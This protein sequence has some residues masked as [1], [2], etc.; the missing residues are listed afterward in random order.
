MSQ[1]CIKRFLEEDA[2]VKEAKVKRHAH[3]APSTRSIDMDPARLTVARTIHGPVLGE[4][5]DT[6]CYGCGGKLAWRVPHERSRNGIAFPVVGHFMHV[7]CEGSCT[8]E[9]V[10]HA[11]AKDMI[12]K[13]TPRVLFKCGS[14]STDYEVVVRANGSEPVAEHPWSH[15]GQQYRLDVAFVQDGMTT[16]AVEILHSHKVS[17]EK[18]RALTI[19]D[20]AWVELA[21]GDVL[22]AKRDEPVRALRCAVQRCT[23]CEE[24]KT[25]IEKN[26]AKLRAE[27]EARAEVLLATRLPALANHEQRMCWEQRADR[28]LWKTVREVVEK[29]L[30]ERGVTTTNDSID[31]V[32]E[33]S[34]VVATGGIVLCHGKHRGEVLNDVWESDQ[35][36]VRWLAGYTGN[37]E[38]KYPEKVTAE[39]NPLARGFVM[40]EV[41]AAREILKGHC[42]LCFQEVDQPWKSWCRRCFH[43]SEI[44]L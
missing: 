37:R 25:A 20:V 11:A 41:E 28:E 34:E 17:S 38:G 7:S 43:V 40:L 12:M 30:H 35:P 23:Q 18:A 5:D 13:C 42:Y 33:K 10:E 1:S 32:V 24:N 16:G 8:N 14:C 27:A 36:Y 3:I 26:N 21:A 4:A 44:G 22:R 2:S 39:R 15:D 29:V 6:T 31:D 19:A 9:S